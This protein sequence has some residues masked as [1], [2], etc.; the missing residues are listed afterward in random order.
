MRV[1]VDIDGTVAR[2]YPLILRALGPGRAGEFRASGS[3]DLSVVGVEEDSFFRAH[4]WIL[5]LAEPEPGAAEV[6]GHLA[7][8]GVE[9]FY[10]TSR[11]PWAEG[12]TGEWLARRGFPPGPVVEVRDKARAAVRLGLDVFVED[13]PCHL[14]ALSGVVPLV[15][16]REQVYNVGLPGRSFCSWLAVPGLLG[17][18]GVWLGRCGG[19]G[20][21]L[22]QQPGGFA[23]PATVPLQVVRAVG[24]N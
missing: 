20:G 2:A 12:M 1:G 10:V 19:N 24:I 9:V 22:F 6:L 15:L 7:A 16:R 8:R 17:L 13:A 4:P 11:P 18:D 5:R 21:V 23:V 3:Y 14:G